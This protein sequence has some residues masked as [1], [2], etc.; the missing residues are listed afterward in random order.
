MEVNFMSERK[1]PI[2]GQTLRFTFSEGP[3]KGKTFE[4][5][6]HDDGSVSFGSVDGGEKT[7]PKD[8]QQKPERPRYAALKVAD[9]IHAVSYLSSSG[10]TLT[11]VLNFHDHQL[12]GF[13]SND[14]QWF[15]VKGSF[16]GD[17]EKDEEKK[18]PRT[19]AAPR[20]MS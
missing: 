10:Y 17:E 3:T 9:G 14:K 18:A 4:H 8:E 12:V 15:P 19:D 13:A 11:V 20:A 2:R 6:F 5:Q 7:K 16:E 1:D